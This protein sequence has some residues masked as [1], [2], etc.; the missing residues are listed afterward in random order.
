M[1][2]DRSDEPKKDLHII[3][4]ESTRKR[5]KVM[6]AENGMTISE[7]CISM[8]CK[9]RVV[10]KLNPVELKLLRDVANVANNC[11]QIAKKLNQL[12]TDKVTIALAEESISKLHEI[13]SDA[14]IKKN[15]EPIG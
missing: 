10:S 6:A 14:H 7:Y 1:K 11:N 3:V 15:S 9:G 5:I 13:L 4:K 2:R 8:I 12:E